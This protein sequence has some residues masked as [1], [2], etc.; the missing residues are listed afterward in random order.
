[1]M[2][3]LDWNLGICWFAGQRFGGKHRWD[4]PLQQLLADVGLTEREAA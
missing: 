1:M 4:A 2:A 3:V